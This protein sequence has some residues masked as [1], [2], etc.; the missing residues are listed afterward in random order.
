[1]NR[2]RPQ[3]NRNDELPHLQ[4]QGSHDLSEFFPDE[5]LSDPAEIELAVSTAAY[6]RARQQLGS[7]EFGR[8]LARY[9]TLKWSSRDTFLEFVKTRFIPEHVTSK[10]TSSRTYY[11]AILKHIL[12]PET[13]DLLFD[14]G[15]VTTNRRQRLR[16]ITDW[17][18]LDDVR[19]YDLQPLH[20]QGII[21]AALD[22]GYSFETVKHI[23]SVIG[24]IITYATNCRCFSGDNPA[25]QVPFSKMIR[26]SERG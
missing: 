10:G 15:A 8:F 9:Y 13:V 17:P 5:P 1:M 6:S 23:R 19:L 21:T 18:Y 3:Q 11:R 2:R 26:K 22:S 12:K 4:D 24:T 14:A 16:A 25:F 20:V 7:T